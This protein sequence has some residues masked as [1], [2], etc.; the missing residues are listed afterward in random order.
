MIIKPEA[1]NE[2][3]LAH[4]KGNFM[5]CEENPFNEKPRKIIMYVCTN[6][7]QTRLKKN[8]VYRIVFGSECFILIVILIQIGD[9]NKTNVNFQETKEENLFHFSYL[10]LDWM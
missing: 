3:Q 7:Y 10:N 2:N 8:M 5:C 1:Q 4:T 9:L 6:M